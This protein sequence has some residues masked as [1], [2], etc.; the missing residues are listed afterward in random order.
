MTKLTLDEVES[1]DLLLILHTAD[2]RLQ[3]EIAHTDHREF[4]DLLRQ[5]E[6]RIARILDRL[7]EAIAASAPA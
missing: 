2:S 7:Q 3:T 1:S 5:R 6:A 4:R